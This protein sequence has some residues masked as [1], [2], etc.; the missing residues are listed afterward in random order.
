[1]IFFGSRSWGKGRRF[2]PPDFQREYFVLDP[3]FDDDA[4]DLAMISHSIDAYGSIAMHTDARRNDWVGVPLCS[5]VPDGG[6]NSEFPSLV[7]MRREIQENQKRRK[8]AKEFEA[9]QRMAEWEERCRL[10]GLPDTPPAPERPGVAMVREHV[11]R[12]SSQV[13]PSMEM[14]DA[15]KLHIPIARGAGRIWRNLVMMNE[16][17]EDSRAS[18]W[19]EV[20]R[21]AGYILFDAEMSS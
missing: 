21:G 7:L 14:L 12:R 4:N 15:M 8:E 6:G 3:D 16:V 2:R 20:W 17:D 10:A 1:M 11:I 19:V 13:T 18:H 9:T 5:H